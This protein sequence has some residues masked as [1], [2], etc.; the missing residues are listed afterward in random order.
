MVSNL[1][2]LLCFLQAL[3]LL[4]LLLLEIMRIRIISHANAIDSHSRGNGWQIR[5]ILGNNSMLAVVNIC[6][7]GGEESREDFSL[8]Y[9][10]PQKLDCF[11]SEAFS[12]W[13][14][15]SPLSPLLP[16]LS[17]TALYYS[18]DSSSL[19]TLVFRKLIKERFVSSVATLIA[20]AA[21]LRGFHTIC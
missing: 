6:I 8:I 2:A 11:F 18:T 14:A 19:H 7:W 17:T 3:L 1:G 9:F 10:S 15:F 20:R 21:E 16:L 13:T 12:S 5:R 4:R